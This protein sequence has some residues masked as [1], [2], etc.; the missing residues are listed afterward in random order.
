V[1]RKSGSTLDRIARLAGVSRTAVSLVLS[2]DGGPTRIGAERAE[3]IRELARRLGYVANYH[4]TSMRTGHAGSIAI[5]FDM[6]PNAALIA[7]T[8]TTQLGTPFFGTLVGAIEHVARDH[9]Y[10][11]TIVGPDAR[12][13]AIERGLLGL[14]QQRFD[15]VI[16]LGPPAS[17]APA[18]RG[19]P[20]VGIHPVGGS[21]ATAVS[22]DEA[23]GVELAIAHLAGRGHRELLWV[24]PAGTARE[25][26]CVRSAARADLRIAACHVPSPV[27]NA[28]VA[29]CDAAAAALARWMGGSTRRVTAVV[30]YNEVVGLG[31]LR[32]AQE[33]GRRIPHDLSVICFDDTLAGLA[34]PPL[35]TVDLRFHAVGQRA[36]EL[37][38]ARIVAARDGRTTADARER[39]APR[40]VER[41]SV[42]RRSP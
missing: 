26:A 34:S 1:P 18:P 3:R 27:S 16:L 31:A 10:L 28:L 6:R 36:A 14:R 24:G 5:A 20:V 22:W 35:T 33:S 21:P 15:G 25:A 4:A 2:A 7:Q 29:E 23:A 19:M 41:A 11:L 40:L 8:A 9:G 12:A 38:I 37:L 30:A 32:A 13:D 17:L 42:G 39:I